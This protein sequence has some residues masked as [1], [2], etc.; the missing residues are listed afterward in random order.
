MKESESSVINELLERRPGEK[1]TK[2]QLD[3]LRSKILHSKDK[4]SKIS[5]EYRISLSTLR[6]I[7][8]IPSSQFQNMP[9]R[10][11][12][13]VSKA[14]KNVIAELISDFYSSNDSPFTVKDVQDHLERTLNVK[15][16]NRVVNSIM[17]N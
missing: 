11:Y 15:Y 17:K 7:R 13:K 16:S 3:F 5:R 14:E 12:H 2:V 6:S 1:L 4:I 10:R 9:H 8:K